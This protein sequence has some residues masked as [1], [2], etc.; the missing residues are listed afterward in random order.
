MN[1]STGLMAVVLIGITLSA[2]S[3][4]RDVTNESREFVMTGNPA[5]PGARGNA[6]VITTD[7]GN[8]QVDVKVEHLAE[9]DKITPGAQVFVVWAQDREGTAEPQN[10]GM[11]R[12]DDD[13]SGSITAVTPMKV[14]DLYITAEPTASTAAPTGEPI[15]RTDIQ[16]D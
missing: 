9:P 4:F 2:C 15:L 1:R 14:F 3:T 12:V 11:L 8:T 6:S 5:V 10:L 7:D 16:A 13:L